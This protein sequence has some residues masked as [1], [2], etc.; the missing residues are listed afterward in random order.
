MSGICGFLSSRCIL[1]LISPSR[2]PGVSTLAG[3]SLNWVSEGDAVQSPVTAR[4][5]WGDRALGGREA[6]A[7]GGE[8]WC[9]IGFVEAGL[10]G[11]VELV[12]SDCSSW[13]PVG[14]VALAATLLLGS[15]DWMWTKM[16]GLLGFRV[17]LSRPNA[18]VTSWRVILDWRPFPESIFTDKW[19][20]F[21]SVVTQSWFLS[22]APA[23]LSF[24]S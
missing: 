12:L 4:C 16:P 19:F 8:A 24:G 3:N 18:A 21:L 6:R 17:F 9:L 13:F 15:K 22:Q 5:T 14:R 11:E 23:V 10:D 1:S 7:S 2:S 20:F